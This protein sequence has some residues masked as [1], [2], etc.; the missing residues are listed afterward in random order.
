MRLK[1]RSSH[2]M[3]NVGNVHGENINVRLV[4]S[5]PE[6]NQA[7]IDQDMYFYH[8]PD[9]SPWYLSIQYLRGHLRS[10]G[11]ALVFLQIASRSGKKNSH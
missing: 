1:V 6:L 11:Q 8:N 10:P 4:C 3:S 5:R 7:G 9:Y 2:Q